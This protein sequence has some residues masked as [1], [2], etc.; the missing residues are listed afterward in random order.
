MSF[1][2]EYVLF[3]E[4]FSPKVTAEKKSLCKRIMKNWGPSSLVVSINKKRTQDYID[5]QAAL[6]SNNAANKDRKNLSAMWVYGIEFLGVAVNPVKG[7]VKRS[8]DKKP[9]YVPPV[10]DVLKLLVVA[11]RKERIFLDCYIHTGARRSEIFKLV[12]DDVNFQENSVRLGT[13]KTKDG[14]IKYRHI[15]ISTRLYDSLW[16]HW[17]NRQFKGSPFVFIDDQKG[18]HFGKPYKARRRFMLGLCKRAGIKSFGFH[19]LRHFFSTVLDSK[20]ISLTKIQALLGH[21][22]ATTTNDYLHQLRG[23]KSTPTE[24][25]SEKLDE[26]S[27]KVHKDSTQNKKEVTDENP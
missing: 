6:R 19:A 27:E 3:A 23:E 26:I 24:A 2:S 15:G 7:T 9:I 16:W 14:S 1:C 10:E 5:Q 8:H 25:I 18:P 11:T 4:R 22:K 21:Q 13:R 17:N 12:W 20:N